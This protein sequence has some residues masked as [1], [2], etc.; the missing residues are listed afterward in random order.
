M[1]QATVKRFYSEATTTDI[2]GILLD[3]RPVRT[4]ARAQ[5]ILPNPELAEAV[6]K[7]WAAQGETIDPWSMPLTGLAN[8]AID[9]AAPDPAKFATDLARYADADLLCYR[10]ADPPALVARQE[11]VWNPLLDW[12]RRRYDCN[13]ALATGIIHVSQPPLSVKRLSDALISRT[14]FELAALS[15]I[16]SIAGSL[17]IALALA[18]QTIPPD[19]A[20]D[21]AHLDELW[22]AEQWGE[23]DFALEARAA[24]RADFTAA[25]RFL[26]LLVPPASA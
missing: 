23:D 6:R 1:A 24:R 20:F 11:D 17:I 16:I 21:A 18:E 25:A 10:A 3:D 12:A 4:P 19:A 5:L 22:Q 26:E 8:A 2:G 15:P 9:H 14:T 13:F 7:E